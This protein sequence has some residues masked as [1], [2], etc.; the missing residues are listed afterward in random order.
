MAA[1][2]RHNSGDDLKSYFEEGW[3]LFRDVENNDGATN[4]KELQV[5]IFVEV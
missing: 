2:D 1:I 4:S 3:K 5:S